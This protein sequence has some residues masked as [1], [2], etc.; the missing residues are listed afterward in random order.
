MEALSFNLPTNRQIAVLTANGGRDEFAMLLARLLHPTSGKIRLGDANFED[1]PE[2]TTGRRIVYVGP[3]PFMFTDTLR[4]NLYYGLKHRPRPRA[5]EDPRA[6]WRQRRAAESRA[7]GNTDYDFEADW[8]DYEA[9]GVADEEALEQAALDIL[10]LVEMEPD[11]YR[12]GLRGTVDPAKDSD[13]AE[14]I[15]TART[16]V[17]GRLQDPKFG[18]LVELFDAESFNTS[19]TVA[20]NLLFGT[21]VDE[22]FG[23]EGMADNP[24]V[25]KV[26]DRCGLT[27]EFLDMG[28]RVAE[29]M[30]ELFADLQPGTTLLEQFSFISA[31]DLPEFQTLVGRVQK[32]GAASLDPAA[33]ARL[34]SLPFK[35]IPSRHRLNMVDEAMQAR[36]VEARRL[37]A[38]DLPEEFRDSVEFFD[39]ARYNSQ[40]TLQDNI[41]FGKVRYGQAN[42]PRD[43]QGLIEEVVEKVGLRQA[44]MA[45]GLDHSVGVAGARLSMVQRQKLGLARALLKNPDLLILNES[46]SALDGSAQTRIIDAVRGHRAGRGLIW[47]L[48]RPG[49]ARDFEEVIV[50]EDGRLAARGTF[51]DLDRDDSP[52]RRLIDAE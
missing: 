13:V 5:G 4:A 38:A 50:L 20:E 18:S 30:V 39:A 26:L 47:A 19:A 34:M 46:T 21:P 49:L 29:T 43:V 37:F 51:A 24:Y 23:L 48:H 2:A 17:R 14:A 7:A 27:E 16:E 22:T 45:V 3:V 9:V 12:M 15:L 1:L 11:V 10:R 31:D 28:V 42:A 35:L 25:L 36:L 8:L 33:R 32:D 6:E 52:L 44:I 41:L 40:A